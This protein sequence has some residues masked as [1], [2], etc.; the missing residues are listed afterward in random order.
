MHSFPCLSEI[1][2]TSTTVLDGALGGTRSRSA[3]QKLRQE[4]RRSLGLGK[5]FSIGRHG[6]VRVE[7][8]AM[9]PCLET[10]GRWTRLLA[11][12]LTEAYRAAGLDELLHSSSYI[13][14]LELAGEAV[15]RAARSP[16]T[17][18]SGL[19]A[20]AVTNLVRESPVVRGVTT[21]MYEI[22]LEVDRQLPEFRRLAGQL[23]RI[24]GSRAL[25]VVDRGER[26]ELTTIDAQY[27]RSMGIERN[28]DPFVRQE[29]A[30]S[31]DTVAWVY[32]PAVDL[33]EDDQQGS[34]REAELAALESPLPRPAP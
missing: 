22:S 2:L 23:V 15:R 13:E 28:G 4:L 9:L 8:V 32:V 5:S 18:T 24:E 11:H 17:G 10:A 6:T 16:F 12:R 3:V 20:Q 29:L 33:A 30:W 27:L 1:P 21:T 25:I 14:A 19:V 26:E 31:P 34:L 7:N